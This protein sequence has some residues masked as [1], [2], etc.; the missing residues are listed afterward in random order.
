MVKEVM[1]ALC[2]V[3]ALAPTTSLAE[4]AKPSTEA[5]GEKKGDEVK[6]VADSTRNFVEMLRKRD[7]EAANKFV[8][9]KDAKDKNL[10]DV[11][12]LQKELREATSEEKINLYPQFRAANK[13]Y[14]ESYLAVLDH[15]DQLD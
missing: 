8:E 6:K 13:K 2:M 1:G 9:L 11:K 15:L 14:I 3:V 12:R 5:A 10:A 7:P 4:E